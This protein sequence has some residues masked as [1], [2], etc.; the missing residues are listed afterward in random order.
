MPASFRSMLRGLQA[1]PATVGYAKLVQDPTIQQRV[2]R[3]ASEFSTKALDR[4]PSFSLKVLE[5]ILNVRLVD[6][7]ELPSY[8]EAVRELQ[9]ACTHELQRLAIRYPDYFTVSATGCLE[10]MTVANMLRR[11]TTSSNLRSTR[12]RLLPG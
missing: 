11:Y 2:I 10:I 8:S 1:H 3:V 12:L 7:P 6:L 5:H 9:S 4:K